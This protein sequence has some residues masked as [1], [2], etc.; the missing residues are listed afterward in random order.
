MT[1]LRQGRIST[2]LFSAFLA[3]MLLVVPCKVRNSI[4]DA[5][6]I[7]QTSVLN[8]SQTAH[9][10]CCVEKT[11]IVLTS[12]VET[13]GISAFLFQPDFISHEAL[14]AAEEN[15]FETGY[16][17]LENSSTTVPLYILYQQYKV[18]L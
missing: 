10:S 14:F 16:N 15:D 12:T 8:K 5:L 4:E 9:H 6:G 18:H 11:D 13:A 3:V 1:T 2:L 7:P 17:Y